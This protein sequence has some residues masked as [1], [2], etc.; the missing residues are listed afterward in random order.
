MLE[1]KHK[2]A[3]PVDDLLLESSEKKS[4]EKWRHRRMQVP[5]HFSREIM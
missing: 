2:M 1:A 5:R 4:L 3:I